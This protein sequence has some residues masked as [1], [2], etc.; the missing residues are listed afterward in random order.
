MTPEAITLIVAV[1]SNSAALTGAWLVFRPRIQEL[2]NQTKA[3][4]DNL[5]ETI[6]QQV[7]NQLSAELTR[8]YEK[9]N[10]LE[11]E[12]EQLHNQVKSLQDEA[13][14]LR[15][16]VETLQRKVNTLQNQNTQLKKR[17][18]TQEKK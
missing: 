1:L 8:T 2:K 18:T 9:N 10:Q 16:Q 17:L 15:A 12:V 7:Y 6:R 5:A 14:Q 3:H 13:D 4:D 11:T